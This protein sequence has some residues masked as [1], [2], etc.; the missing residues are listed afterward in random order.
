MRK[1]KRFETLG[2]GW[3]NMT[4]T[5]MLLCGALALPALAQTFSTL[6]RF[7]A[8]SDSNPYFAPLVQGTDGSL[9]GTTSGGGGG[10][11]HGSVF[12]ITPSGRFTILYSFCA[13]PEC[14]DGT[15]PYAGLVQAVDGNF[16][17]TAAYGGANSG[18]T[19]FRIGPDGMLATLYNFCAQSNCTDGSYP[20]GGLVQ[21]A[22][23]KLYGTTYRGG[24]YGLGTVFAITP[25]GDF[26]TL[27]SFDGGDGDYPTYTTL[28]EGTD[29][30]YGTT[31]YGGAVSAC[32]YGCGTVF[33]ITTGGALTTLHSFC[34]EADCADGG[35]PVAPLVRATNGSF[36]GTTAIYGEHSGGTVF[37]ITP[38]GTLTTLHSFCSE[39][40]C[41][42]GNYSLGGLTQATDGNLYGTTSSGGANGW[43][44]V[45]RVAP[46]GALTTLYNFCSETQCADGAYPTAALAE[47]TNGNLYGTA[48]LGG[49]PCQSDGCG[50]V[51]RLSLGFEPF[52][53][54]EPTFGP[55]GKPVR[56]LGNTLTGATRVTFNGTPA[57]FTVVSPSLITTTVPAGAATGTVQVVTPGGTLNSNVPFRVLE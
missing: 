17:G 3:L 57:T 29:G 5:A 44:T 54:T 47:D 45:F 19:V 28:V 32:A 30:L 43:G 50:T 36:Y 31:E 35:A 8:N 48:S 13:E 22:D 12:R 27:H 37:E 2:R 41:A 7:A 20:L 40:N 16:Y 56:I 24:T 52:V 42:D 4:G 25:A 18:G 49:N 21:A 9:Y 55:T 51:F 1:I 53:R 26:T 6:H 14:V 11:G 10:G 23:G 38:A 34:S 15:E 46:G 39:T 33:R